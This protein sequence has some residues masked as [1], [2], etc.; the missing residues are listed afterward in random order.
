MAERE[1]T[2]LKRQNFISSEN[3]FQNYKAFFFSEN[4]EYWMKQPLRLG[5][6]FTPPHGIHDI[7]KFLLWWWEAKLLYRLYEKPA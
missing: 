3:L 6:G 2:V 1:P 4:P 7:N 5:K